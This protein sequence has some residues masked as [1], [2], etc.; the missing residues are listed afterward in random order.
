VVD[1]DLK[2][3]V[4]LYQAKHYLQYL[5]QHKRDKIKQLQLRM[6]LRRGILAALQ[7]DLEQ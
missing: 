1:K 3:L 7:E 5:L 2:E 4:E 6:D